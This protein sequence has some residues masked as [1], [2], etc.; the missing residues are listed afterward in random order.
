MASVLSQ[1]GSGEIAEEVSH[2]VADATP[3]GYSRSKWVAEQICSKAHNSTRLKGRIS[4]F[5]VGQLSGASETGIW[6]E[7]EAWPM[8]LSTV[9]LTK[10]LP[11][12]EKEPLSWLPVDLAAKSFLEATLSPSKN[13]DT[14]AV[15]HVLNTHQE[16]QWSDLLGWLRKLIAFES[17]DP[18][19]WVAQLKALQEKGE[20][21]PALK[22]LGHWERTLSSNKGVTDDGESSKGR[23]FAM[24][25]TMEAA[26]IM[27]KV[28]PVD[29]AYFG[30]VW[31][32]VE[33][34]L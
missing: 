27:A 17:V 26:P 20:D 19:D 15:Y 33:K 11:K 32:W 10:M 22:L 3:L 16:P 7:K 2:N 12:I 21:H 18:G 29:E 34:Q 9:K 24:N 1:Q 6:N 4:V 5:R 30:K 14:M 25:K 31:D 23:I 8:M 13:E 28:R